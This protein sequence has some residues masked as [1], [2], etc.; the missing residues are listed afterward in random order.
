MKKL[1]LIA[2]ASGFA[3]V[4]LKT[5]NGSEPA[6]AAPAASA[7]DK[8]ILR[9]IHGAFE[10]K[11]PDGTVRKRFMCDG[12]WDISQSDPKTGKVIWHHGG[13]YTFDG[14]HYLETVDYANESTAFMIGEIHK[15]NVTING[16]VVHIEGLG[17]PW[18]E[19]WVRVPEKL[20]PAIDF[21]KIPDKVTEKK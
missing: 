20:A 4:G 12:R 5:I 2:C 7:A 16:D 18:N 19:E 17:N 10:L 1:I 14:T 21:S 13:T 8:D 15:F 9:S 11:F 6:A 3:F